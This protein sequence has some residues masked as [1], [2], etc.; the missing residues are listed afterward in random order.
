MFY[1][2]IQKV[3][4]PNGVTEK[5]W[6][7]KEVV[8]GRSTL[9]MIARAIADKSTLTH[10]DISATAYALTEEIADRLRRGEIV[11]L[12]ELGNFQLTIHN[13][14]G[15]LTEK[16]WSIDLIKCAHILWRPTKMIRSI[17]Q[18]VSFTRWKDLKEEAAK[19]LAR[20]TRARALRAKE[21]MVFLKATIDTFLLTARQSP[22]SKLQA[23]ELAKHQAD[24]ALLELT[25]EDLLLAAAEAKQAY[26]DYKKNP[27]EPETANEEDEDFDDEIDALEDDGDEVSEDDEFDDGSDELNDDMNDTSDNDAKKPKGSKGKKK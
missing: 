25:L 10:I 23:A 22:L 1:R 20:D 12:G 18:G 5:R 17:T 11:E 14:G 21:E 13:H 3:I 9:A 4:R 2:L 24:L 8:M 27:E 15:S 16:S 26:R 6:Y 7:A 19:R